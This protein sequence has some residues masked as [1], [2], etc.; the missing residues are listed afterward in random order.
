M[1]IEVIRT[2]PFGHTCSK[3]VGE[4]I[5][6]CHLYITVVGQDP[7][8]GK[9]IDERGC[10]IAWQPILIMEGNR[11]QRIT[12]SSVNSLRNET[13]KRQDIALGL[14]NAKTTLISK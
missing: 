13:V 4:H 12:S 5:E 7:A 9:D 6:E 2:C 8:T 3:V 10:A 11:E 14:V 1:D